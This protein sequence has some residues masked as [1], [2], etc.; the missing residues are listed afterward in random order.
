MTG[1]LVVGGHENA[2]LQPHGQPLVEELKAVAA[3]TRPFAIRVEGI[4]VFPNSL[5][6]RTVWVGIVSE[7]LKE[8]AARVDRAAVQCGFDSEP[9]PFTP[10]IMIARLRKI[11]HW[12]AIREA[13]GEH[14]S[15]PFGA[16]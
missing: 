16:L 10:H 4:G 15:L 7:E 3:G 2:S 5:R 14:V 13:V 6:P 12:T 9:R 11:R 1:A 8:L